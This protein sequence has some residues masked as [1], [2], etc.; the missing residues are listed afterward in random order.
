MVLK[1]GKTTGRTNMW[2]FIRSVLGQAGISSSYKV[3]MYLCP[4]QLVAAVSASQLADWLAIW[5]RETEIKPQ[6]SHQ[7]GR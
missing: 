2:L 6:I 4:C 3:Y 7:I 5:K 1:L